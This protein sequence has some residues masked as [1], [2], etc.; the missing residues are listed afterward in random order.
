MTAGFPI[1][2]RYGLVSQPR[3]VAAS[4]PTNIAEGSERVGRQEYARFLNIADPSLAE[5]EYLLMVSRDLSY[6]TPAMAA[7]ALEEVAALAR[8]LH[9]LREKVEA[10][11]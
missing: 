10:A 1:V 8:M 5:T 4:L 2:E 9:D 11:K 7:P 3:R 6:I